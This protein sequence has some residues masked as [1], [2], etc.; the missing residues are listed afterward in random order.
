MKCDAKPLEVEGGG[1]CCYFLAGIGVPTA[2]PRVVK[3]LW[4]RTPA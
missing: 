1:G 3:G 4:A 2:F